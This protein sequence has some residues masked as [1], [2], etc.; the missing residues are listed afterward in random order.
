M[1]LWRFSNNNLDRTSALLRS[2]VFR[3]HPRLKV[4][5][6]ATVALQERSH[7]PWASFTLFW[8]GNFIFITTMSAARESESYRGE[9]GKESD[10]ET[11]DDAVPCLQKRGR[12]NG[13]WIKFWVRET[14]NEAV[15]TKPALLK[16]QNQHLESCKHLERSERF[17]YFFKCFENW[18]SEHSNL[19]GV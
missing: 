15:E 8:K 5:A 18:I 2:S 16:K 1:V 12:V 4:I 11:R 14:K 10:R 19:N 3:T 7:R 6:P 9:Q 17:L 13:N